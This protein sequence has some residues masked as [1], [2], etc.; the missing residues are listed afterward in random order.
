MS[1]KI[2]YQKGQQP[3]VIITP[4]NTELSEIHQEAKRAVPK[5][6]PYWI[7][8]NLVQPAEQI[9]RNAWRINEEILG[10]PSGTGGTCV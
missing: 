4:T 1:I 6:I 5:D 7:V 9:F 8:D 2:V 10:E 3:V